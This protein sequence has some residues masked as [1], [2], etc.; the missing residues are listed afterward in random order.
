MLYVVLIVAVVLLWMDV[1]R[2]KKRLTSLESLREGLDRATKT[3]TQAT[4]SQA[5]APE[6]V[7]GLER[8]PQA[9]LDDAGL[10]KVA[11]PVQPPALPTSPVAAVDAI[12]W[13]DE[14]VAAAVPFVERRETR[15][16]P[17]LCA[18]NVGAAPDAT[19][20]TAAPSAGGFSFVDLVKKNLFAA[21]G[22]G[23][24]LLGF[25][26][27]FTSISWSQ[28]LPPAARIGLVWAF[29]GG[30]SVVG[31][32]LNSKN[33]LWGQ[34]AQGGA[35][36]VAY[37]ATYVA[38]ASYDLLS[39]SVALFIFA[40]LSTALVARALREDSKVLA[41][42]GFLGAYAA[43]V[44]A[45][46]AQGSLGFNLGYGL[47]VTA[48]ALWSSQRRRWLELAVH[49]HVCAAGMAALTYTGHSE[50]LGA[51]AQ[52]GFLHAYVIQFLLWCVVW[53]RTPPLK[54]TDAPVLAA[55]CAMAGVVYLGMQSWLLG[56]T[57]FA[58]SGAAACL[59]FAVLAFKAFGPGVVRE[60]SLVLAASSAAAAINGAGLSPL[61]VG[62]GLFA[63][64]ALLSL[65]ASNASQV[66]RWLARALVVAGAFR[67]L[68]DAGVAA[69][70]GLLVASFALSLRFSTS[71]R[72]VDGWLYVA[73]AGISAAVAM[74]H[75]HLQPGLALSTGL[76]VALVMTAISFARKPA[77]FFLPA[78]LGYT[79]LTG[80]AWLALAV[81]TAK[82][83]VALQ[84]AALT[85]TL[86]A[87]LGGLHLRS[88]NAGSGSG[89]NAQAQLLVPAFALALVLM[90]ALWA[91]KSS[92]SLM[93][94]FSLVL[95]GLVSFSLLEAN[96][97]LHKLSG[98]DT[99]TVFALNASVVSDIAAV[100]SFLGL[101][102]WPGQADVTMPTVLLSGLAFL[103]AWLS[104]L[105]YSAQGSRA[106]RQVVASA[107]ALVGGYAWLYELLEGLSPAQA[108]GVVANSALLPVLLTAVGVAYVFQNSKQGH[109]AAWQAAATVCVL[110]MVKLLLS[111]GAASLS[112]LG[113]AGSLLGMGALFL[114]AGYVAPLPPPSSESPGTLGR[115]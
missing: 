92:A 111:L 47:V 8:K 114:L 55:C 64:G 51:L 50:P 12:V 60:T 9:D 66:R 72:D 32:R 16:A 103:A 88:R 78:P 34:I 61:I 107:L 81:L 35:A 49:A 27:L 53:M 39:P 23:L 77:S 70:A 82:D 18:A 40:A 43:P 22:I 58:V 76:A 97:V 38:S 14:V 86:V 13:P 4:P 73:I 71:R 63:E 62:M 115:S 30:L 87:A 17:D 108:W 26:F 2:L 54:S 94:T 3:A 85:L 99:A 42:I 89:L 74:H 109:R 105:V 104:W 91:V 110:A 56:P 45:L 31:I 11:V 102:P 67:L 75:L 28:L 24:L 90:P 37:L 52:Q 100:I 79:S 7:R 93:L 57:G 6:S 20:A 113:I 80:L 15:S 96:R 5:Q 48:A 112:P 59:V 101:L 106:V 19:D 65:T 1:S 21:A 25:A 83:N 44:L 68:V 69:S 84:M 41:G 98:A 36:A 33:K 10:A 29:A 95:V 46:Q